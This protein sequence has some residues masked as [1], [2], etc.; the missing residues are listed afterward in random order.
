MEG[1]AMRI[2]SPGR[3]VFAATMIALGAYGLLTGRFAAVW[4]PFPAGWAAARQ[5]LVYATALAALGGGAGLLWRRA[6]AA[7]AGVLGAAL[8]AWMLAVKVP[9]VL[10]APLTVVT[11]ESWGETAA[12]AAAAWALFAASAGGRGLGAVGGPSGLRAARVLYGAALV[13]FGAAHL[14]YAK[15]TASLV[16]GWLPDPMVWA[17]GTGAT[18]ILAGL[19]IIADRIARLAAVLV[20]AQIGLFTLL[21]WIPVV[22]GGRAGAGQ[23]SETVISWTLTAAAWVIAESYGAAAARR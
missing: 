11:W 10:R 20:A 2:G 15:L 1:W 7:A 23:W 6:A 21:V 3:A 17:Y 4:Q 18:Y 19:A 14:A 16:P 5:P 9:V 12:I 8:L 22:A 13:A